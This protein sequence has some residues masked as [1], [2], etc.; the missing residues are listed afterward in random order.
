MASALDLDRFECN[1]SIYKITGLMMSY[2]KS[3]SNYFASFFGSIHYPTVADKLLL[4]TR[5]T[6]LIDFLSRK[7]VSCLCKQ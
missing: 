2:R 7:A 6:L 1:M 4:F 3:R 5:M